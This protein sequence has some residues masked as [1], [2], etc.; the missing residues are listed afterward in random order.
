MLTFQNVIIQ[1]VM[2]AVY[3]VTVCQRFAMYSFK[4]VVRCILIVCCG[5]LL[6]VFGV[7]VSVTFHLVCFH[8]II[9]LVW[10]SEWPLFGKELPTRVAICSLCILT[11]C[12]FSY[13]PVWF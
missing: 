1:I 2:S 10:V 6:P 3:C 12:D 11:I 8:I 9:S 4:C 13:L 5:S 7:R